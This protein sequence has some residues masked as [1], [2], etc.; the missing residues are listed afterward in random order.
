MSKKRFLIWIPFSLLLCYTL[1]MVGYE[2]MISFVKYNV[3]RG[4]A[5]SDYIGL[6]NYERVFNMPAVMNGFVNSAVQTLLYMLPALGIGMLLSFLLGLIPSRKFKS[7]VAGAALLAALIPTIVLEQGVLNYINGVFAQMRQMGFSFPINAMSDPTASLMVSTLVNMIPQ[8]A[9]VV[10]AGLSLSISTGMSPWKG[11]LI[12]GLLPMMTFFT[13]NYAVTRLVGNALNQDVIVT[14]P[15]LVFQYGMQNMQM[16]YAAALSTTVRFMNIFASVL[17]WLLIGLF[18]KGDAKKPRIREKRHSWGFE[19]LIALGVTFTLAMVYL[20]CQPAGDMNVTERYLNGTVVTVASGFAVMFFAF[21]LCFL[22]ITI[23]RHAA[24]KTSFIFALMLVL[25]T[26]MSNYLISGYMAFRNLGMINTVFSVVFGSLSNPI[27]LT[28]LV[29]LLLQRPANMRQAMFLTLG[30]AFIAAACCM[31]DYMPGYITATSSDA[32]PLSTILQL[33]INQGAGVA[34]QSDAASVADAI[35]ACK[36]VL[37]VAVAVAAVPG[38]TFVM[39]GVGGVQSVKE[40]P[41]EEEPAPV[42]EE[43]AVDVDLFQGNNPF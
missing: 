19:M 23:S 31:G 30:G 36:F 10:F 37:L 15:Q 38:V 40:I 11:A 14:V 43:P 28:I 17:P 32:R 25:L 42:E 33:L 21:L 22:F 4:V 1:G 2:A 41:V 6:S 29:L 8:L 12:A 39:G 18:V 27:F 35:N 26:M 3:L 13:P 20:F 34:A 16:S 24:G 9:L 5:G 7:A